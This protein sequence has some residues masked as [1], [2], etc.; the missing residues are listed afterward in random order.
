V[1]IL[2]ISPY[3]YPSVAGIERFCEGI[4]TN[5]CERG[6][7]VHVLTQSIEGYAD[8]EQ[9]KEVKVHRIKPVFRYSKAIVTPGIQEKINKISP[10]VIHIQGPAPGMENFVRKDNKTRIIMTCHTDLTLNSST[11]YKLVSAIYRE[12]IFPKV[13]SKLDK[14]VLTSEAFRYNF[15]FSKLFANLNPDKIEIIPNAVDVQM[16][17]PGDR[18]KREYKNN[19]NV[20]SKYYGIFVASM[21]PLHHYKGAEY[22]LHAISMLKD[23]DI[24]FGLIGEGELKSEYIKIA[25]SLGIRNKVIFPGYVDD[26]LLVKH[27]RAADIFVVP[28]IS[29]AE[30]QGIVLIEAMAC[31]TPII[32]TKIHGPQEMVK[33]GY[34]GYVVN[35]RDPAHLAKIIESMLIEEPRLQ[36]MQINARQEALQKF[37]WAKI[38]DKYLRVYIDC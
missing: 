28:S 2:Y 13:V 3:Y 14:V 33:E 26:M 11:M 16:F 38:I 12:F 31:G 1:R 27:Y 18:S 4:A 8:S 36:Q 5:M 6:N 35:P 17:S 7:E 30:A 23:L 24:T 21:E 25:N 20:H 34:N 29:S 37:S 32:T 22:L 19:L 15:K 10:D 9:I